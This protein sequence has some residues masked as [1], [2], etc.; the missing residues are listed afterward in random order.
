MSYYHHASAEPFV[1][2]TIG[3][4]LDIMVE[5]FPDRECLVFCGEEK[6]Y[7]YGSLH[8]EVTR[9]AQILLSLGVNV[10]DRLGVWLPTTSHNI[11]VTF[12]IAKVGAIKV[13]L[14]PAY[15]V[16]E[17]GDSLALTGCRGLIVQRQFKSLDDCWSRLNCLLPELHQSIP[18]ALRD[19][20][21]TSLQHVIL[22]SR[23]GDESVTGTF[24]LLLFIHLC[25]Q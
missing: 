8:A 3:E 24:S 23:D 15:T 10:G 7:T 20:I 5:Q 1:Y 2:R 6:R 17:L 18:G 16:R 13:N 11:C 14:N 21:L 9:F 25:N 19:S 22:V 4:Q 12:A